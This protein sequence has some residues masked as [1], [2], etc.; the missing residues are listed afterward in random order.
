MLYNFYLKNEFFMTITSLDIKWGIYNLVSDCAA[1]LVPAYIKEKAYVLKSWAAGQFA[2]LPKQV[3]APISSPKEVPV[4]S[5]LLPSEVCREISEA[6]QK[7]PNAPLFAIGEAV[8]DPNEAFSQIGRI[9]HLMAISQKYRIAIQPID[10]KK[11]IKPTIKR[12]QESA[13][14]I[15]CFMLSGHGLSNRIQFASKGSP[16]ACYR[17]KDVKAEDFEDLPAHATILFDACETALGLAPKVS[18]VQGRPVSGFLKSVNEMSVNI[19]ECSAGDELELIAYD[20]D[21]NQIA[22]K[23]INGVAT[24][25]SINEDSFSQKLEF[26]KQRAPTLAGAHYLNGLGTPF[27][28]EKAIEYF[29]KD[30]N[31]LDCLVNLAIAKTFKKILEIEKLP[32]QERKS[33]FFNE[34]VDLI[35]KLHEIM[36]DTFSADLRQALC[37]LSIK[38]DVL[39]CPKKLLSIVFLCLGDVHLENNAFNQAQYAYMAAV[40]YG[41]EEAFHS[42]GLLCKAF[43]HL[44]HAAYYFSCSRFSES[45]LREC[46]NDLSARKI[47]K[48]TNQKKRTESF[49]WADFRSIPR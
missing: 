42:L 29:E 38:M 39:F 41:L 22:R 33:K 5:A 36:P 2:K 9:A 1:S 34:I 15:S 40:Q 11:K 16:D 7:K 20:R 6:N 23:F 49:Y 24:V 46:L 32:F 14:P 3:E 37:D 8:D 31:N 27:S 13:G 19:A 10:S 21:R 47:V 48:K 17:T 25:P 18:S 26:Y 45:E 44:D 28:Y 35:A 4:Q 12:I 43:G 30:A